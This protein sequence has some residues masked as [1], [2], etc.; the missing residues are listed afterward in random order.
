MVDTD[1]AKSSSHHIGAKRG[2]SNGRACKFTFH[3]DGK[4]LTT[5]LSATPRGILAYEIYEGNLNNIHV[6]EYFLHVLKPKLDRL[7]SSVVLL[8]NWSGHHHP[9]AIRTINEVTRGRFQFAHAYAHDSK[10]VEKTIGLVKTWIANHDAEA[11][12]HPVR[13]LRAALDYYSVNGLGAHVMYGFW[14]EHYNNYDSFLNEQ[15]R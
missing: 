3:I 13:T 11:T 1:G 14:R 15:N 8:D 10:P 2:W 6:S 7:P 4:H 9:N 5:M 12:R